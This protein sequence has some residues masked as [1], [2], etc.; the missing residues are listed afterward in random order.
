MPGRSLAAEEQALV[1]AILEFDEDAVLEQV[2]RLRSGG[3]DPL[4]IVEVARVAM[5]EVG[6]R[7]QTKQ[8][9]LTEL[10]MG[11]ELLKST[12]RALGF[13]TGTP[14][15][16]EG[17]KGKVLLGTVAGD[18]H[19]IGKNIVLSLLVANGYD[20]V[21]IGVDVPAGRFVEE[22]RR[23]RPDVVGMCGLLTVAFDSM[24]ATVDALVGAGLRD[25]VK[26]IVGGGA[27]DQKVCDYVGADAW[28]PT[29]ADAVAICRKWIG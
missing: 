1:D 20:V 18:I 2:Q 13:A 19:D 3:K 12:M 9:F 28:G 5:D 27:V 23:Y 10:I 4:Q 22:V 7:F 14:A 16:A 8:L 15:R 21:D 11:G 6:Q 29:A 25:E 17:A 26:V 24:K